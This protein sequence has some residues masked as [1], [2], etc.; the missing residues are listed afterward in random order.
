MSHI[1]DNLGRVRD[2]MHRACRRAR[3]DPHD[4]RLIVVTKG[5]DVS[6]AVEAIGAGAV[7]V[8]ESRVQEAREKWPV[9]RGRATLHLIG[10]LQTNKAGRAVEMFDLIH[11]IDSARL[12]EAVD[13]RAEAAGKIQRVLLEVNTSGDATK[14]GTSV[15]AFDALAAAAGRCS[16]LSVDGLMTIGPLEGGD[17]GA[18]RSFVTLRE[19][20]P[21]A[22]AALPGAPLR[23]L[24]MGMSGDFEIAIEEGATMVR[25]GSAICG[26]RASRQA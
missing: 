9:L 3:R 4:V 11:S 13:R 23:E 19:L 7:D 12:A 17:E 22:R 20:L 2:R 18:R 15:D 8:G 25:V 5:F 21:R 1:A 14:H 26:P 16:H 10:H 24:S 6:V